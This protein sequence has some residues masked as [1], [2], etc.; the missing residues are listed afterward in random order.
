MVPS[1]NAAPKIKDKVKLALVTFHEREEFH[2]PAVQTC[3][4]PLI[5]A[6]L[7]QVLQPR[8]S[9]PFTKIHQ[10]VFLRRELYGPASPFQRGGNPWL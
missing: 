9:C 8:S 1:L 10:R 2:A 5:S 6:Q 3:Q 4:H 7:R